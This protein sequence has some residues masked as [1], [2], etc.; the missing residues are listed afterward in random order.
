MT[1][2]N[3]LD[4]EISL[5]RPQ[6]PQNNHQAEL[7]AQQITNKRFNARVSKRCQIYGL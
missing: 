2:L 5:A 6:L 7:K 3:H 1:F 4:Q